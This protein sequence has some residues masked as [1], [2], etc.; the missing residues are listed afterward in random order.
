[1]S[2]AS[3]H[4]GDQRQFSLPEQPDEPPVG[5]GDLA[6]RTPTA[7]PPW[8]TDE[9]GTPRPDP[10]LAEPAPEPRRASAHSEKPSDKAPETPAEKAPEKPSDKPTAR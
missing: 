3:F 7:R 2:V 4:V 5:G 8:G 9:D 10:R 6:L 1:M